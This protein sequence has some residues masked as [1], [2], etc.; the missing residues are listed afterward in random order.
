MQPDMF[1]YPPLGAVAH[2]DFYTFGP[3]ERTQRF[4][5]PAPFLDILE[6][7]KKMVLVLELPGMAKEDVK[8]EL[9]GHTITISG[10]MPM[11]KLSEDPHPTA[12]SSETA[13]SPTTASAPTAPADHFKIRERTYGPFSRDITVAFGTEE[14]D[15]KEES[16]AFGADI[17][18]FGPDPGVE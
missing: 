5:H 8:I 2:Q 15:T 14:K 6:D 11:S 9:H 13:V 7:D 18:P 1:F 10:Y 17:Y 12:S 4:R 3:S 16:N